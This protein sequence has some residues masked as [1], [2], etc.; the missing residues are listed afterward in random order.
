VEGLRSVLITHFV[1]EFHMF[2]FNSILK[3]QLTITIGIPIRHDTF[4][5][6]LNVL[7]VPSTVT[8]WAVNIIIVRVLTENWWVV[9]WTVFNSPSVFTINNTV[10]DFTIVEGTRIIGITEF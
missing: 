8:F 1:E 10:E 5:F 6:V 3:I 2:R 7:T 4:G 9:S